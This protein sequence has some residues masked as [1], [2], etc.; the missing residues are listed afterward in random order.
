[1]KA[2]AC[3][4]ITGSIEAE[5]YAQAIR[6][7]YVSIEKLLVQTGSLAHPEHGAEG[8]IRPLGNVIPFYSGKVGVGCNILAMN[9]TITLHRENTPVAS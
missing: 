3:D 9:L 2:G 5:K 7:A 4:F 1:M 8:G 6:K